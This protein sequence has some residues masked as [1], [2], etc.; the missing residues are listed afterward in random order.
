MVSDYRSF[1]ESFMAS[2]ARA[3]LP[4]TSSRGDAVAN[5][6]SAASLGPDFSQAQ[7]QLLRIA[8]CPLLP[9]VLPL[10]EEYEMLGTALSSAGR[11]S[12]LLSEAKAVRPARLPQ[13]TLH[14]KEGC[15]QNQEFA[16]SSQQG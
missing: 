13:S 9:R 4:A 12:W 2:E 16:S 11:R 1:R 3:V 8:I 7:G 14:L 5:I 10:A 6:Q 15:R